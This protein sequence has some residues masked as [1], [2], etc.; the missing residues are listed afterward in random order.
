MR[1]LREW[2]IKHEWFIRKCDPGPIHWAIWAMSP[3]GVIMVFRGNEAVVDGW[4]SISRHI[5]IL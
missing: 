2:L 1:A 3:T 4:E 5:A